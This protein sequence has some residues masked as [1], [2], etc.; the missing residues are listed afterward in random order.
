M[1]PL[2][3][4]RTQEKAHLDMSNPTKICDWSA[5]SKWIQRV[6]VSGVTPLW[7]LWYAE[8]W[9]SG[10]TFEKGLLKTSLKVLCI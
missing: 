1:S 2:C 7:Y 6:F 9:S 8:L 10:G 5:P 4:H 3:S